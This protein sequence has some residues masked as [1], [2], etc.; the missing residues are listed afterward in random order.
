MSFKP[1]SDNRIHTS[2]DGSHTVWSERFR[3]YYHNP[4]GAVAE[5]HHVFFDTPR[6]LDR[7]RGEDTFEIFEM[8][9]GTGL[10]LLVLAS[11]VKELD[12]QGKTSEITFRSVEAFPLSPDQASELN[13][14]RQLGLPDA[15]EL[16][17]L[18]F[19]HLEPGL[20][21]IELLP[22]LKLELFVGPFSEMPPPER[23]F[24]A[25]FFDPFSP[26]V[27]P[28]LW[29]PEVFEK[30]ASWS[31][32]DVILSTYGAA[33]SARA[34]MAVAGWRAEERR[35]GTALSCQWDPCQ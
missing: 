22:S 27:N 12:Q 34:A 32:G 20:N 16:P 8:G 35:V 25:I 9:F 33:S 17:E 10:N 18:I 4:N 15:D 21:T 23:P 3:Q 28:D 11:L 19:G 24:R 1:M 5:S 30:L 29:T 7:L 14:A 26:D 13:H 6:L 2:K 31:A